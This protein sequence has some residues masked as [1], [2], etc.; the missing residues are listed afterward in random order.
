MAGLA[1]TADV[2]LIPEI[3]YDLDLVC[4][5][6][7]HRYETGR[8]FAIVVA[9]EG[10]LP[11]EGD[12]VFVQ[13]GIPGAA[14]RYGGV[15]EL[16]AAQ[17]AEKTGRETRSLVLGHL[18]RGGQPNAFDRVLAL[19]FGSAA[20]DL[21]DRGEFACM[22]ALDPPNV[23]A[24]PLEEAISQLKFVPVDGDIVHTARHLGVS[25][26]DEQR[27]H[28]RPDPSPAVGPAQ[29]GRPPQAPTD[30]TQ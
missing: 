6:I 2:I 19:R 11:R 24:V 20:V 3:P 17:I 22:V 4:K 12:A 27:A 30:P 9:A 10:A 13:T 14:D 7:Q 25:F 15:A 1:G 29:A 28:S 21:I 5:K 23:V 16:L 26:G 18:Q 8:D